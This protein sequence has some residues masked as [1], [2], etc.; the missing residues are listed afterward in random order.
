MSLAPWQKQ[1]KTREAFSL[2]Q[3]RKEGRSLSPKLERGRLVNQR[4]TD[5]RY[6]TRS[7]RKDTLRE[8]Q[9]LRQSISE[10]RALQSKN[11]WK[12]LDNTHTE[13][14]PRDR[15]RYHPYYNRREVTPYSTDRSSP[16]E[17][18]IK[19]SK[20]YLRDQPYKKSENGYSSRRHGSPPDS[21][22]TVSDSYGAPRT[23]ERHRNRDIDRQ[24]QRPRYQDPRTRKEWRPVQRATA[25]ESD[26]VS[27]REPDHTSDRGDTAETEEE[28]R[29]KLKGKAHVVYD[30]ES[31]RPLLVR[32]LAGPLVIREREGEMHD[33]IAVD[34]DHAQAQ[35]NINK[36]NNTDQIPLTEA[37]KTALPDKPSD[38][39]KDHE[40]DEL[41]MEEGE[42]N[43]MVDYYNE[44]GMTED[45]INEDDLL[46]DTVVPETQALVED[47]ENE[48]IEAIAQLGRKEVR[49][50][51]SDAEARERA[52][53]R[54]RSEPQNQSI[55]TKEV[56]STQTSQ[57]GILK[58]KAKI[59][60]KKV[61]PRS[62]DTKG[63]AASRKLAARG[64]MSPRSKGM[65]ISRPPISGRQTAKHVPRPEKL[66]EQGRV[67]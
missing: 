13:S 58:L 55:P 28:K 6:R 32:T 23:I 66:V 30:A 54:Q 61:T 15:E 48:Q 18:R 49:A 60:V 47:S 39:G 44:M 37:T 25:P 57:K 45:M 33:R 17:W 4:E 10:K 29:R 9:D 41:S 16:R 50:Q 63:S 56:K 11:V 24:S 64:R 5:V 62:P 20:E 22:R 43:K 40:D 2:P 26:R 38:T 7:P 36:E 53:A 12:R 46:D 52:E 35:N 59:G 65:K 27:E 1:E 42:F 3:A 21:Q 14:F 67:F 31:P 8:N 19:S 51:V 34:H